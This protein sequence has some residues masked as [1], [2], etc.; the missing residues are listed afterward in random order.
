M[1]T[2]RV[3]VRF[4]DSRGNPA[5]GGPAKV[6]GLIPNARGQ[7]DPFGAHTRVGGGMASEIN[8]PEPR[9]TAD[10][11]DWSLE[12]WP[13]AAGHIIFPVPRG[14]QAATLFA[15]PFDENVAYKTRMLPDGPLRFWGGGRLGAVNEDR[16]VTIVAY[17]AP[18]VV[19]TVKAE[20][21]PVP[22]DLNVHAGF[23]SNG[24]GYGESFVRN[25][26]G[27]FRSQSLMPDHEYRIYADIRGGGE[28]VP[29]RILHVKLPEG[30]SADLT[31]VVRKRPKPPEPGRPAPAF[32]VRTMDGRTLSLEALRGKTVLLHFWSLRDGPKDAPSLKAVHDRFGKDDRF[33][34][35]GLCLG[36]E[37]NAAARVVESS[38]LSWPQAVLIDDAADPI[39]T[40]YGVEPPYKSFLVGPNGTVIA[41]DL[42]GPALEKAVAAAL[43]Q[44]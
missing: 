34:M 11:T 2:V 10:R 22:D 3:E 30:G 29:R 20:D 5:R 38:G 32:S 14:L 33:A 6:W 9:D 15:M 8:D 17:R 13:D 31:M 28:Y 21:G 40:D 12:D 4:V 39:A 23:T 26:D 25:A 19:L 36:E 35:V 16:Q 27:R 42:D 44:K 43:G 41:R 24:G 18:M 1:P 7:A 37:P